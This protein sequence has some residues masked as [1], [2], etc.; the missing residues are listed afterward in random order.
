[1]ILT[2]KPLNTP[3]HKMHPISKVLLFSIW[4]IIPPILL[5]PLII[6]IFLI[7]ILTLCKIG[8]LN[9]KDHMKVALVAA[10][11]VL[12]GNIYLAIAVV[13]PEFFKVY[14][15]DFMSITFIEITP[16]SFPI[17]GRLALSMGGLI[18]LIHWPLQVI[19]VF[20][21]VSLFVHV[22]PFSDIMYVLSKLKAPSQFLFAFTAAYRFVP[23]MVHHIT[24]VQNA[25][26]LRGWVLKTK[27]PIKLAKSIYTPI[28][29]PIAYRVLESIDS[30]S[31]VTKARGVGLT[32]KV[33]ILKDVKASKIDYLIS[34]L[35]ITFLIILLYLIFV[36]NFGSL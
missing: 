9:I 15:R 8:Q 17:F 20:L 6:L 29:I 11:V 14:P 2:Y 10:T 12:I 5:D 34:I 28:L 35:S 23:D 4:F 27:N 32:P 26:K 3:L 7:G 33:P 22:T 21:S 13:N 30:F 1:M 25:Q 31:I 24:S 18:W 36:Y 16:H 19:C